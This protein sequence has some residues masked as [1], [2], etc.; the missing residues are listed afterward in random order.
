MAKIP[1]TK[2]GKAVGEAMDNA[3]CVVIIAMVF[4]PTLMGLLL[5]GLT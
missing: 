1:R 5:K 2:I 3:G 4:L